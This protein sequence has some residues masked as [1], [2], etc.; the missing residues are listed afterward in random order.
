MYET[1]EKLKKGGRCSVDSSQS[2]SK[3]PVQGEF[4]DSAEAAEFLRISEAQ[5]RNMASR[6]GLPYYKFGARNRYSRNE[7]RQ[8]I[9]KNK[10]GDPL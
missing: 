2:L 9:L 4:M 1:K 10:R 3:L 6:G 7:L 5:L 8:L